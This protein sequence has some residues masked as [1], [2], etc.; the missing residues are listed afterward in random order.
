MRT[1]FNAILSNSTTERF[2]GWA[3]G[4][5]QALAD[6]GMVKVE[7]PGQIDW[8]TV[9]APVG[10]WVSAGFEI[11]RFDDTLQAA[12]PI[13]FKVEYGTSYSNSLPGLMLTVGKGASGADILSP[14]VAQARVGNAAG[15]GSAAT[16]ASTSDVSSCPGRACVAVVLGH[17]PA[18]GSVVLPA[19]IIDRSRDN[20]GLAT[21]DGLVIAWAHST[22]SATAGAPNAFVA[23]AYASGAT[24]RGAIPAVLPYE[25][26][27]SVLSASSS[28]ATGIIAP[29]MPWL[30]FAPG[31]APWQ[32]LAGLTYAPGD[33]VA[34]SV[35]TVRILGA[36]RTYKVIP[37]NAVSHGWGVSLRDGAQSA[38]L[39]SSR[40]VGLMILWEE[41]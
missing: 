35:A 4:L 19:F 12:A 5:S 3:H 9:V 8:S 30:A 11:W 41:D 18:S 13:F 16:I 34:G 17:S 36:D 27:G 33:A 25:V 32:P 38:T 40:V 2:L 31:L 29:V 14:F 1:T 22:V 7:T 26:A 20:G 28:L 24:N 15:G 6:V 10:S 39:A 37:V 21:G 23:A